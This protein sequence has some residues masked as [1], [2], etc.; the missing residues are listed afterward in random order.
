MNNCYNPCFG[1]NPFMN[2]VEQTFAQPN[3]TYFNNY[4]WNTPSFDSN[5]GWNTPGF[6]GYYGYNSPYMAP[7]P[8]TSNNADAAQQMWNSMGEPQSARDAA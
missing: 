7:T 3:W 5:Y 6:G 8:G 1:F 2:C 4:G